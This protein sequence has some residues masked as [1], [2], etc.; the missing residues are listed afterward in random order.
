MDRIVAL[1]SGPLSLACKPRGRP[2]AD[3]CRAWLTSLLA[4]GVR[5]IAPEIA[6]YEVRRELLRVGATSGIVRLD[7]LESR[8]VYDPI[9]TEIMRLA[10]RFWADARRA[11]RPT[12]DPKALDADVI[13]AAHAT[14]AGGPGDSVTVATTNP[15]HLSRYVDARPWAAIMNEEGGSP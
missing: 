4:A 11:G 13:L 7:A 2:E 14:L 15:G 12:A 5:V 3:R 10:A 8:L 6:D 9:T 1:D